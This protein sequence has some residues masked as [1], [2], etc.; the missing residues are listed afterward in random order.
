MTGTLPIVAEL[1][2]EGVTVW[3]DGEQLRFRS[4]RPLMPSQLAKLAKNKLAILT[5]LGT[6][7]GRLHALA[8][9][10]P[11]ADAGQRLRERFEELAGTYQY[12]AG[13][14]K[15]EAEEQAVETLERMNPDAEAA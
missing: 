12:D 8:A 13:L 10:M 5:W 1:A 4:E 3:A 14:A 15:D 2:R 7:A 6:S 9:S 11:D